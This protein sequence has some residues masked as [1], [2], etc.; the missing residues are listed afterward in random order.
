M[1][2]TRDAKYLCLFCKKKPAFSHTYKRILFWIVSL[3]E[4]EGCKLEPAG[5]L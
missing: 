5:M 2:Y 1:Q 4:A 3:L